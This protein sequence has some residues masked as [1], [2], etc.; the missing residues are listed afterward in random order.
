MVVLL[1]SLSTSSPPSF[2]SALPFGR[3]LSIG[4]TRGGVEE[5][6]AKDEGRQERASSRALLFSLLVVVFF[7]FVATENR[8]RNFCFLFH[9]F[10]PLLRRP[11]KKLP[12]KKS[13]CS[14]LVHHGLR[15][16][17]ALRPGSPPAAAAAGLRLC[18]SANAG[19]HA[20]FQR[21]RA[22]RLARRRRQDPPA[23]RH[24][25]A[26]GSQ[27]KRGIGERGQEREIGRAN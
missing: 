6:M 5:D 15:A 2:T 4:L 27:G 10:R 18:C 21:P 25:L 19:C 8:V 11:S 3:G 16:P 22:P 23:A 12:N 1:P 26:Q 24:E 14:L 9:S 7:D 20:L 17:P 13:S